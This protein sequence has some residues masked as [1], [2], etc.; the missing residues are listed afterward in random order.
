MPTVVYGSTGTLGTVAPCRGAG[1]W[2]RAAW[3]ANGRQPPQYYSQHRWRSGHRRTS[4]WGRAV[5]PGCGAGLLGTPTGGSPRSITRSTAGAPGT[6][7]PHCGAGLLGMPAGGGPPARR[8]RRELRSARRLE[9]RPGPATAHRHRSQAPHDFWYCYVA[10]RVS[11]APPAPS[12]PA[13]LGMLT[14]SLAHRPNTPP[15]PTPTHRHRSQAPHDF[16]YCYV[17]P[18]VFQ[19]PPALS[20]PA[21]PGVLIR[22]AHRPTA[23]SDR[24]HIHA[25]TCYR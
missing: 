20:T 3:H 9:A 4:L 8:P 24:A 5:G 22:L 6:V 14:Y 18:R 16:W 11:Q 25:L 7:A 2:G 12:T 23:A 19:A 13:V 21:A 10:P 17:A 15:D 1:L